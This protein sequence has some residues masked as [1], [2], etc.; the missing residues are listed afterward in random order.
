ML[1]IPHHVNYD[2]RSAMTSFRAYR[3][4]HGKTNESR[5]LLYNDYLEWWHAS[6]LSPYNLASLCWIDHC[7]LSKRKNGVGGRLHCTHMYQAKL[8]RCA[9]RARKKL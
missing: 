8:G 2:F 3:S 1:T 7:F 6:F 4:I 5:Q 9:S